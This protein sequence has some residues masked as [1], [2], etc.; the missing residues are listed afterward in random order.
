MST[1]ECLSGLKPACV[2]PVLLF[3][4]FGLLN[5]V[6]SCLKLPCSRF[7]PSLF[8]D[9]CSVWGNQ[10]FLFSELICLSCFLGLLAGDE[11][12]KQK[13]WSHSVSKT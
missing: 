8:V 3:V 12:L 9:T 10:A 4:P 6:S 1:A 7:M 11:V 2:T 5:Q 13:F